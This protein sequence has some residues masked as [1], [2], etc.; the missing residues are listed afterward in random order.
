MIV[1]AHEAM[2]EGIELQ[3]MLDRGEEVAGQMALEMLR[4]GER[5]NDA[6]M[7]GLEAWLR[8]KPGYEMN[9][10]GVLSLRAHGAADRGETVLAELLAAE[11]LAVL[12]TA[13]DSGSEAAA[14][15]LNDL[16][17]TLALIGFGPNVAI[18][19]RAMRSGSRH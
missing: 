12:D 10:A 14:T 15:G 4:L 13:A 1:A 11:A 8:K 9:L 18:W 3:A 17:E 5:P 19:A 6:F 7:E 2:L 16:S